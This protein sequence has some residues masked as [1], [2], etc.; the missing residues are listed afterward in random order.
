MFDNYVLLQDGFC[1]VKRGDK[2]T[3]FEVQTFISYYR[4]IPISMINTFE[5]AVDG[6]KVPQENI[7]FSPD[8][9]HYFTL[10]EMT[11][12]T[13]YKWEYGEPGHVYVEQPGGL[14]PG[15]HEVSLMESIRISYIPVPFV[16]R[17]TKRLQLA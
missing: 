12:V 16:G 10:Q 8:G 14:E 5:I 1:N 3:G 6:K 15:E 7:W 4:G 13:S 17:S 9:E 2:I 11:T